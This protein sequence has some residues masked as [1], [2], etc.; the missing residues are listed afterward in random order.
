MTGFWSRRK[1]A[2][3]AE[4]E[5]A[6]EAFETA[7]AAQ[8]PQIA[9]QSDEEF[10]LDHRLPLPEEADS[11]EM[12]RRFLD[13]PLPDRLK[14]RALRRLWRLNPVL[15]N[16]DGLVDYADD[17]TDAATCI[18]GL[19]TAYKVGK[20]LLAH[21]EHAAGGGDPQ[22]ADGNKGDPDTAE[23]AEHGNLAEW[24][25]PGAAQSQCL[26]G[27]DDASRSLEPESVPAV[28]PASAYRMKFSFETS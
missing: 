6:F 24:Q 26:A 5:A 25:E 23:M 10:L 8:V 3:K 12:V 7:E 16:L 11:V 14:Q 15:A 17:Y 27:D 2:V 21:V 22:H 18:P 28:L 4:K 1:A 13:A 19:Q 9:E 20:G